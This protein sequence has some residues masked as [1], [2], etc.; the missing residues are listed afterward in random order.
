MVYSEEP[1]C[2]LPENQSI[3]AKL[4]AKIFTSPSGEKTLLQQIETSNG[5]LVSVVDHEAIV[6]IKP[7][8][9]RELAKEA[10]FK[11]VEFFSNYNMESFNP[12]TS[13]NILCVL[14]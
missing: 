12:E 3:R 10:G 9:I 11:N 13:Q 1:V 5:K 14:S 6:T 8:E 4:C 2:K 7:E